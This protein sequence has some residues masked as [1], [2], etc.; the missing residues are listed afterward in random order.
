ME[1]NLGFNIFILILGS[2]LLLPNILAAQTIDEIKAN[3]SPWFWG[4][5]KAIEREA[6]REQALQELSGNISVMVSS[7]FQ[8][9]I[10]ETNSEV[11][12]F[13]ESVVTTYTSASFTNLQPR[14]TKDEKGRYIFLYYLHQD[15][16]EE[17]YEERRQ[18]IYDI[19]KNAETELANTNISRALQ[20]YYYSMILMNSVPEPNLSYQGENL[21]TIIPA[22]IQNII[23]GLDFFYAGDQRDSESLRTVIFDLEYDGKPVQ[24]LEFVYLERGTEYRSIAKDGKAFCELTGASVAYEDL[25]IEIEYRFARERSC[26]PLVDQIWQGVNKP[27]FNNRRKIS[28][29]K[30]KQPTTKPQ[31]SQLESS[32]K[33]LEYQ[34]FLKAAT[35][36]PVEK[37]INQELNKFMQALSTADNS[38]S[39]R[40]FADD[41]FLQDKIQSIRQHNQPKF[42]DN[43][44]DV[45][46]NKSWE[47]WE[48]RS[49]PVACTYSD[50]A[51]QSLEY[52][53]VDFAEDG[54]IRD[55]NF[56][57]FDELYNNFMDQEN[58]DSQELRQRQVIIKFLEKYR[59]AFLARDLETLEKIFADEAVII[60]GRVL[61]SSSAQRNYDL[62]REQPEIEYLQYSKTEYLSQLARIFRA[63]REIHLAFNSFKLSRKDRQTDVFGVSMRQQYRSSGYGDEGYLFLLVDFIGKDPLIYVRSWQPGEWSDG[64]M[65]KMADFRILE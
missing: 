33:N 12:D 47:G 25:D 17:E 43:K 19:Y 46:I 22:K 34:F 7:S 9:I 29:S 16:L 14:V 55:F 8:N 65:I 18:L 53:V 35:D 54:K 11:D 45:N 2:G 61:Q 50:L 58:L 56:Q 60:V 57:L 32:D 30:T 64:E 62:E 15:E 24:E 31:F 38:E 42:L 63:Q 27:Y 36:C 10:S 1:R 4:E 3:D 20:Y 40:L 21:R 37:E 13:L 44:F 41:A 49:I 39:S 48:V 23:S 59:T 26:I 51:T 5:G 6:A 28:F 52:I